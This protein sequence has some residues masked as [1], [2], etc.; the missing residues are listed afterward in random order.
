MSYA[1]YLSPKCAGVSKTIYI[2]INQ[3][4]QKG[5]VEKSNGK[6]IKLHKKLMAN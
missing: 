2:K 6:V 3:H 5:W 4:N 1:V